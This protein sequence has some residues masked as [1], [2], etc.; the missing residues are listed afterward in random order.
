MSIA[1]TYGFGYIPSFSETSLVTSVETSYISVKIY[2][3]FYK[4]VI[5]EWSIPP[6]WGSC[7]FNVYKGDTEQGEFDKVN[8]TPLSSTNFFAD[9]TT[10][11]FSKFHRSYYVVE[12]ILPQPDGRSIKSPIATWQNIRTNLMG[13]RA[14]EITRRET[15]LLDKFVGV[16]TLIFRKKYFGERCP[17][18]YNK[19]IEKVTKDHCLTCLGTSF[20]GGYFPGMATKMCYEISPNNTQLTYLGKLETNQTSAWTISSPVLMTHDLIL[21]VPDY[22][23]FRIESINQTELQTVQVRQ[24]VQITELGKNSVEMNLINSGVPSTYT[25]PGLT[26]NTIATQT[27]YII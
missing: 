8:L 1:F 5:V 27:G 19:D 14:V 2:P 22:K 6:S 16:D 17:N 12:V 10:Q 24:V 15:I 11:D 21:R 3:L 20:L 9:T 23:L 25:L 18:C 26:G 13:I 4:K 7:T